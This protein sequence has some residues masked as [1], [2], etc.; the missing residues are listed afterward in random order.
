MSEITTIPVPAPINLTGLDLT[1]G[2]PGSVFISKITSTQTEVKRFGD[3]MTVTVEKMQLVANEMLALRD[4]AQTIVGFTGSYFELS[5]LP[6]LVTTEQL[7][8]VALYF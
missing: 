2:D 5:D 1:I 6:P 8:A 4:Q 7:H 3:E